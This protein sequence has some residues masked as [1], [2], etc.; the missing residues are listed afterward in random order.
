MILSRLK[1]E[2][3]KKYSRIVDAINAL[4][5][6][7]NCRITYVMLPLL[8]DR[9]PGVEQVDRKLSD[10]ARE[11]RVNYCN[12]VESMQDR[13]YYYDHMHF[14]KAGIAYFAAAY[15]DPILQGKIVKSDN[16]TGMGTGLVTS[17]TKAQSPR[18][19]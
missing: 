13:K 14:N 12:L 17:Q 7:N 9:F 4:V 10:V 15:L 11:E 19:D 5:K 16:R 2:N 3:F 18:P 6:K 1:L 8:I